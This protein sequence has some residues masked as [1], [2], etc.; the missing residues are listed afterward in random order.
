MYGQI[1]AMDV[2]EAGVENEVYV[3]PIDGR[4]AETGRRQARIL[5]DQKRKRGG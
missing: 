1:F 3:L 5:S 4:L 2:L